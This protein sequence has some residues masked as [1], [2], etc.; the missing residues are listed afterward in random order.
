MQS[1]VGISLRGRAVAGAVAIPFPDGRT[2]TPALVRFGIADVGDGSISAP[3]IME[4]NL[5]TPFATALTTP[6]ATPLATRPGNP[7]GGTGGTGGTPPGGTAPPPPRGNA[8]FSRAP[9][10]GTHRRLGE[11]AARRGDGGC[12]GCGLYARDRGR[13]WEQ[14]ARAR[15]WARR[16]RAHAPRHVALGYLRSGGVRKKNQSVEKEPQSEWVNGWSG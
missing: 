1:L 16:P 7:P 5:A 8:T 6:L 10:C 14:A 11:R 12:G 4:T 15:R 2:D 3:S 13:R 9:P